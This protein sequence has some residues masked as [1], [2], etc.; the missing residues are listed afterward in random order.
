MTE[1]IIPEKPQ[2]VAQW[3]LIQPQLAQPDCRTCQ[4]YY[5]C[6]HH[7]QSDPANCT[8]GDKYVEAPKVVLWR[9]E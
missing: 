5:R 1:F 8:N 2:P 9:T 6:E 7:W 3:V 4:R